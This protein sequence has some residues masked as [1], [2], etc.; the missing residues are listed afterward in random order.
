MA[1]EVDF[2]Q[3]G[4]SNGDAI[5]IRYDTSPGYFHV[6][7]VDGGFVDTGERIIEH[8]DTCYQPLARH[9]IRIADVVLTHMDDDHAGGLLKVVQNYA[10]A[11]LWMNRPWHFV[12]GIGGV[13]HGGFTN[14]GLIKRIRDMNPNMVALEELARARG[15]PIW[16]AFQGTRIGPFTVLAPSLGRFIPLI[17]D[18]DR[19]PQ[20]YTPTPSVLN[21][22]YGLGLGL[23][24]VPI[25]PAR[26]W[27]P[28]HSRLGRLRRLARTPIP[29]RRRTKAPSCSWQTLKVTASS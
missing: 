5:C 13:F 18:M 4:E 24:P 25:R 7:V 10:V 14:A 21:P 15:I 27:S 17:P 16:S 26:R 6:Q 8:I 3:A 19:T 20:S 29:R 11:N 23:S 22:F 28:R 12:S 9:K 1:F 2:L